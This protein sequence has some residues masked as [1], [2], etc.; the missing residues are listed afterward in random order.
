MHTT[1]RTQRHATTDP[2]RQALDPTPLNPLL[3]TT[4]RTQ[5]RATTDP[6]RQALDPPPKS[7]CIP[8]T[9]LAR[10]RSHP[11]LPLPS[12]AARETCTW[13]GCACSRCADGLQHLPPPP[14]LPSTTN[15]DTT[16]LCALVSEV[17]HAPPHVSCGGVSVVVL[18]AGV[19][20]I[21]AG[22]QGLQLS[23]GANTLNVGCPP[24]LAC[25]PS[26]MSPAL[27]RCCCAAA[28][29]DLS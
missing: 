24:W 12:P 29:Q 6:E 26:G 16:T 21:C 18:C 10:G 22:K 25:A 11:Q 7:C 28:S 9:I 3:H 4:P 13:H 23:R 15:L 27:S 8:R 17:S 20:G 2:E 1:P 19:C 5:R 14:P